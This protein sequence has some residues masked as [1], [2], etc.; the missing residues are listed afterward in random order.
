MTGE[1][2][3]DTQELRGG[4]RGAPPESA[5]ERPAPHRT[6]PFRN[7]ASQ[8]VRIPKAMAFADGEEVEVSREGDVVTIRPVRRTLGEMGLDAALDA[9]GE[10]LEGFERDQGEDQE[11]DW[12]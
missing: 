12:G 9:L 11:R 5:P 3:A 2:A 7:G 6:K 8:A 10:A 4:G 1:Q